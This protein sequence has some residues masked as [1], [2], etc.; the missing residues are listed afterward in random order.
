MAGAPVAIAVR[1]FLRERR[2]SAEGVDQI[3]LR[4]GL[5]ERL[6]RVLAVQVDELLAQVFQ[7]RQRRRP[8]VDPCPA[9]PLR[10]ED[11]A[12]QHFVS[13]AGEFL[14]GQPGVD[15]WRVGGVEDRGEFGAVG[16]GAQL[17]QFEA[18]AQQ[19]RQRIEQDRFSGA[20]LALS[21]Q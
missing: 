9:S 6:M 21:G 11:T 20:G 2:E 7:V 8:A 19:Q 17:A 10:V 18:V 13:V 16:A 14:L 3:A 5:R 15:R 1:Y 4:L 12:Q